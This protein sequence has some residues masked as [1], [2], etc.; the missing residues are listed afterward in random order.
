M[1]YNNE[2]REMYYSFVL[3]IDKYVLHLFTNMNMVN[4]FF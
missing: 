4:S 2:K 3:F 1:L